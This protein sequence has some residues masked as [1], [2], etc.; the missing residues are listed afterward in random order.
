MICKCG[1]KYPAVI[2]YGHCV[3]EKGNEYPYDARVYEAGS[4]LPAW[5]IEGELWPTRFCNKCLNRFAYKPEAEAMSISYEEA[6]DLATQ[7]HFKTL[8][9]DAVEEMQESQPYLDWSCSGFVPHYY[10]RWF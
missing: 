2:V 5:G 8:Q 1:F 4:S 6:K 3:D 9:W 10:Y 7:E